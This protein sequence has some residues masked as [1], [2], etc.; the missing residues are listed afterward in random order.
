MKLTMLASALGLIVLAAGATI[1]APRSPLSAFPSLTSGSPIPA[2]K[3]APAAPAKAKPAPAVAATPRTI[4]ATPT[5]VAP[6]AA[7]KAAPAALAAPARAAASAAAPASK[8]APVAVA[9]ASASVS[10]DAPAAPAGARF[11]STPTPAPVIAPAPES[12]PIQS[13]APVSAAQ[14]KP[15]PL[16]AAEEEYLY[17]EASLKRRIRLLELQAKATE[18]QRK[19]DGEPLA[20][21]GD[22]VNVAAL[23]INP[24]QSVL[25]IPPPQPFRLVSV[26]GVGEDLNADLLTNGVRIS[27]RK[28]DPLPEGWVVTGVG[29]NSIQ[30]KRGRNTM[31]VKIGG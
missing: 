21:A 27:V 14:V 19:I 29:R 17:E 31:V 9:T 4:V 6:Q 23:P 12:V 20:Q 8:A 5:A 11:A 28:G 18:L 16:T 25:D 30:V 26:W 7:P 15:F 10:P 22:S 13:I 3:P 1:A 2:A 24:Q